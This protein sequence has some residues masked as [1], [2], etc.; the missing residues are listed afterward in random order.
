MH[1]GEVTGWM[2]SPRLR[3]GGAYQRQQVAVPF[4][5]RVSRRYRTGGRPTIGA[6]NNRLGKPDAKQRQSK[7]EFDSKC[8]HTDS[9][10]FRSLM[11]RDSVIGGGRSSRRSHPYIPR[12]EG[13]YSRVPNIWSPAG[14][15][16]SKEM[17]Y[18]DRT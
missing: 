15:F 6:R 13:I 14:I 2:N 18:C 12:G 11:G 4:D 16:T 8:F 7:Q 17:V 9:L 1:D 10:K 3:A 5:D